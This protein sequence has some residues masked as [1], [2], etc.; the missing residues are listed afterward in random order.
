MV[1]R[2]RLSGD[3]PNIN[4]RAPKTAV[5]APRAKSVCHSLPKRK[6]PVTRD[7]GASASR[8]AA[9]RWAA[10]KAARSQLPRMMPWELVEF[11]RDRL[12]MTAEELA[13][14]LGVARR[15][16]YVWECGASPISHPV[17]LALER[18]EQQLLGEREVQSIEA[19][20][21]VMLWIMLWAMLVGKKDPGG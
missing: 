14:R 20:A 18:V 2:V 11:R 17:Q 13:R 10:E 5:E 9:R 8:Q 16:I 15:S 19:N 3:A 7:P 1:E 12:G 21:Q 6:K 4:A